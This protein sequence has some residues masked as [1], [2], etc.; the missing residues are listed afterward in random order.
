M[1]LPRNQ[2]KEVICRVSAEDLESS[3]EVE[4]SRFN[5]TLCGDELDGAVP[6]PVTVRDGFVQQHL[7]D[8]AP[9]TVLGHGHS[10]DLRHAVRGLP[11]V[12]VPLDNDGDRAHERAATT[13]VLG[14]PETRPL[15]DLGSY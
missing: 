7:P 15:V 9:P 5:V 14:D 6:V 12:G 11:H 8:A 2:S 4:I 13:F 3:L 10:P 1:H